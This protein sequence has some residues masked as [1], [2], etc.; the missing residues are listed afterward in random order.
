MYF[1]SAILILVFTALYLA[2]VFVARTW[3][4]AVPLSIALGFATALIGLNI[5][6][7]GGHD[8]YSSRRWINALA[9]IFLDVIGG[10]SYIW[11]HRHSVL[12]HTYVNITGHDT[13]ID[14]GVLGRVT[15]YQRRLPI[16]RWQ[17]WYMWPLYG[18]MAIRW[19]LFGDIADVLRGRVGGHAI[20][21]PK[22]RDLIVFVGGKLVFFTLAIGVPNLFHSWWVVLIYYGAVGVVVGIT[23]SIVFQ[24]S[25]VVEEAEFV[26][27]SSTNRIDNA[28]AIHQVEST[29]DFARN[30]RVAAWLL[31][32]LNFQIEH[33]LLP[34]VCHV[35][36]R[37]LAPL[38]EQ[39]CREFGVRYQQHP[40][41]G[42]GIASHFR[43]LRTMGR[44]DAIGA[45]VAR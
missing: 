22:G 39:V 11:H 9:A 2:L 31:G 24:L 29:V 5:Q 45:P 20:P 25:H 34:R 35:H 28:W 40:S 36:Y 18:L 27:P 41:I 44:T 16:H 32:G 1:K 6:H 4:Q 14:L 43:W 10:S 17:H 3:W 21:R 33:H 30:S 8:A 15:P 7:D 26:P 37:A 23:L 13:D 19:Q 42:A 38:V 12:H